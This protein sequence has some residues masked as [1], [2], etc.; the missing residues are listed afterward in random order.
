MK[1]VLSHIINYISNSILVFKPLN[2]ILMILDLFTALCY[3]YLFFSP[4]SILNP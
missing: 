4:F 1:C 2:F 3:F